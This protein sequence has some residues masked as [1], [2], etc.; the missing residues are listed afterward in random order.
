[1]IAKLSNIVTEKLISQ[2]N[3]TQEDRE[4]YAFGLELL[5][6][7]CINFIVMGAAAAAMGQLTGYVIFLV[8]FAPLRS[9]AG[10]YHAKSSLSCFILSNSVTAI[11]LLLFPNVPEMV[12][13]VSG[14]YLFFAVAGTA[15]LLAP[16]ENM[17][18]PLEKEEKKVY[19]RYGR[20]MIA[21]ETV[22]AF[23]LHRSSYFQYFWLVLL[24]MI[25]ITL[26]E[27]MGVIQNRNRS[28]LGLRLEDMNK[29]Q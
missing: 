19:G 14:L 4:I 1:M 20:L 27:I 23:F 29:T 25:L 6:T 13:G 21:A 8:L 10:G 15:A 28:R 26:S 3:I 24:I 17:Q 9:L 22:I 2:K 11:I 5:F 16:V 7:N 18:K 12:T